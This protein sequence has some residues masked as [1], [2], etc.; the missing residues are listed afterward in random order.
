M[1]IELENREYLEEQ[2]NFQEPQKQLQGQD[3]LSSQIEIVLKELENGSLKRALNNFN[4]ADLEDYIT[5]LNQ[6]ED[7]PF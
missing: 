1:L 4:S 3:L 6:D 2:F 7:S 5:K